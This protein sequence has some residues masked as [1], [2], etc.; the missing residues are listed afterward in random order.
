VLIVMP[1]DALNIKAIG[2]IKDRLWTVYPRAGLQPFE[3]WWLLVHR[4]DI[5][6]MRLTEVVHHCH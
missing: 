6:E 2:T 4:G 1:K 5:S 3:D